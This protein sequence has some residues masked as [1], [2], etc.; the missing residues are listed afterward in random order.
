MPRSYATTD[1]GMLL[2]E[3]FIALSVGAK[4]VFEILRTQADIQACGVLAL[5]LR[6]W[7]RA[8]NEADRP[9][10]SVWLNE[11]IAARFIVVDKDTEELLVRTFAKWDGGYKNQNRR[12]SVIASANAVQSETLRAALRVELAKLAIED[13]PLTSR[14]RMD[15]RPTPS[16]RG[17]DAGV[18]PLGRGSDGVGT[19]FEPPRSVVTEVSTH[20]DPET[21]NLGGEP[22]ATERA[23][24]SPAPH[25]PNYCLRHQPDGTPDNCTPCGQARLAETNRQAEQTRLAAVAADHR[26]R[27]EAAARREAIAACQLCD[28]TGYRLNPERRPAAVCNHQPLNPGGLARALAATQEATPA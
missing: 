19:G 26:R 11:L 14:A 24:E 2:D 4:A 22:G 7:S 12:R 13:C 8:L 27:A 20:Q 10:L 3:D 16:E 18:T 23:T 1:V 9:S 15:A 28:H 17:S 5:T 21:R 25:N 6:R